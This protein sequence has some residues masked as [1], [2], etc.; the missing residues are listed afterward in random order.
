MQ[1]KIK[2]E[3]PKHKMQLNKNSKHDIKEQKNKKWRNERWKKY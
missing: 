1:K 3:L 2:K